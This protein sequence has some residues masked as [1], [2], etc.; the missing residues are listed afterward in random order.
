MVTECG[1][2]SDSMLISML[3][4]FYRWKNGANTKPLTKGYVRSVLEACFF[5]KIFA[6]HLRY[7]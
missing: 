1:L 5:R 2:T 3:I 7:V 4:S 6:Q